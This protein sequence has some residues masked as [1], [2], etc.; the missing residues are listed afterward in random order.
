MTPAMLLLV[1]GDHTKYFDMNGR[2]ILDAL[3]FPVVVFANRVSAEALAV[4]GPNVEIRRIPWSDDEQVRQSV[5]RL[6]DERPLF[7]VA[8]LNESLLEQAAE[9]RDLLGLPGMA[10]ETVHRFRDKLLMKQ[11]LDQQ[12]VC[13]PCFA[14][15]DAPERVHALLA[16]HGKLVIKPV[17]GVGSLRVSFI[18]SAPQLASW[19]AVTAAAEWERYE[20]EEYIDGD[21][22]HVN[23]VVRGG[24][25]LLS[26]AAL[27]LQG[28]ANIDYRNGTPLVTVM[29]EDVRLKERLDAFSARVLEVL[30]LED[31]VSHLECFLGR[32]DRIVLCEVGARPGGGGVTHMLEAQFGVQYSYASLML[33][34]GRGGELKIPA[35]TP[36]RYFGLIG[37]RL[38]HNCTIGKIAGAHQFADDFI[39]HSAIYPENG[40]LVRAAAHAGDYVG[41]LVF[42]GDSHADFHAKR[43]SLH[44]RFDAE[45][46]LQ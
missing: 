4:A 10:R 33:A 45:L 31:G 35:P 41:L 39:V 38:A 28:M 40:R 34:A 9:L 44:A 27:Y 13:V 32:D 29:V 14:R 1:L 16:R 20:A 23:A 36:R 26:G 37:F 46:E 18:D 11:L 43:E 21:L 12:G 2:C 24:Q 17:D 3:P 5:L 8:S 30:G 19:Y 6:A 22:Y 25:V 42:A 15:C 7:T